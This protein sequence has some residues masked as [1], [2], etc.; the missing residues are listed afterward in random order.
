MPT[1]TKPSKIGDR[2][3]V[4]VERNEYLDERTEIE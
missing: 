2:N 1:A 4:M 3:G